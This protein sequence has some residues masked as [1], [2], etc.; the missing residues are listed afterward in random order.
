MFVRGGYTYTLRDVYFV[1][2]NKNR[3]AVKLFYIKATDENAA[4]LKHA[5]PKYWVNV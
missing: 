1:W 4:F 3:R 2:L 5:L